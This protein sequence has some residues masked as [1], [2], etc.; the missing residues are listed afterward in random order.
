MT[1]AESGAGF[2]G[3]V[4]RL[5]K[6]MREIWNRVFPDFDELERGDLKTEADFAKGSSELTTIS[7]TVEKPE[8]KSTTHAP[9]SVRDHPNL[10]Q[11]NSPSGNRLLI[12]TVGSPACTNSAH[13]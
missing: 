7:R 8:R 3:L 9:T 10:T 6:R 1:F 13:C 4:G 2:I 11:E 5:C 12:Q